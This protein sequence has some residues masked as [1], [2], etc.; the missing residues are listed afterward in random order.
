MQFQLAGLLS[1]GLLLVD[2]PLF[3]RARHLKWGW[4]M[5]PI[6]EQWK[7][8]M[9]GF[10]MVTT[11]DSYMEQTYAKII[12]KAIT[13]F[14]MS[15]DPGQHIFATLIDARAMLQVSC[16]GLGHRWPSEDG[17]ENINFINMVNPATNPTLGLLVFKIPQR[18]NLSKLAMVCYVLTVYRQGYWRQ[19][20]GQFLTMLL[21]MSWLGD[22][23]A[24]SATG[25]IQPVVN[26]P[27]HPNGQMV[28]ARYVQG[29]ILPLARLCFHNFGWGNFMKFPHSKRIWDGTW[30]NM[31][32][33]QHGNS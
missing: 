20:G 6:S 30:W 15:S 17:M 3:S 25:N 32:E 31:M 18:V 4:S 12:T 10:T 1:I 21:K 23:P 29:S 24:G 7:R 11:G 16:Q 2:H 13:N 19:I 33:P 22:S 5:P 28:K 8:L 26:G 27:T 9:I 14:G